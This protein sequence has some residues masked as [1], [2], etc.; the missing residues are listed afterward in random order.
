MRFRACSLH[1][2]SGQRIPYFFFASPK[3]K[4]QKERRFFI[5]ICLSFLLVF[6]SRFASWQRLRRKKRALRIFSWRLSAGWCLFWL[7]AGMLLSFWVVVWAFSRVLAL[8]SVGRPKKAPS[9]FRLLGCYGDHRFSIFSVF[10]SMPHFF[11]KGNGVWGEVLF[12]F[13]MVCILCDAPS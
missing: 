6:M 2:V 7:S 11:G 12:W 8:S 4:Y 3:K 9:C 13:S 5:H 10:F 1:F